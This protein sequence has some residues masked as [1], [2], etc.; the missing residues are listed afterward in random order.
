MPGSSHQK[1]CCFEE[2]EEI[3][4]CWLPQTS[5]WAAAIWGSNETHES[6]GDDL[7]WSEDY[8]YSAT[9]ADRYILLRWFRFRHIPCLIC[10][11]KDNWSI[12]D[13]FTKW[14]HSMLL[15]YLYKMVLSRD[16]CW[17]R[18]CDFFSLV[19][20]EVHA[21]QRPGLAGVG[22]RNLKA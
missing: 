3:P 10:W 2:R 21:V 4:L 18:P 1:W 6:K 16:L 12:C 9:S 7:L 13:N 11:I 19:V 20:Q 14:R 8:H 15:L 22:F 17:R 5:S